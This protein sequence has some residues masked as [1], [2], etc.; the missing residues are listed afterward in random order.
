M[1]T[2]EISDSMHYA[3]STSWHAHSKLHRGECVR[4]LLLEVVHYCRTNELVEDGSTYD[5]GLYVIF[6]DYRN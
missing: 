1:V 6:H 2:Q 3:L 5:N 4:E